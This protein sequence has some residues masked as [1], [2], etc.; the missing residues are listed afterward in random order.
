[1]PTPMVRLWPNLSLMRRTNGLVTSRKPA[2]ADTTRPIRKLVTPK[3]AA[4]I[5]STGIITP[6]PTA[7][8]NADTASMTT[9]RG[10]GDRNDNF[11]RS[12]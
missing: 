7:T 9:V 4:K 3:D 5:G 11:T 12:T 10:R 6:K 1:M 8:K 2:N